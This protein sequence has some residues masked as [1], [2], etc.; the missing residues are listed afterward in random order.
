[1]E[2]D[3]SL[4]KISAVLLAFTSAAQAG[5][6][7]R[8]DPMNPLLVTLWITLCWAILLA[9]L[10]DLRCLRLAK[11]IGSIALSIFAVVGI[12]IAT[13]TSSTNIVLR[14]GHDFDL[15]TTGPTRWVR[16]DAQN[17][18]RKEATCRLM[19]NYFGKDNEKPMLT[20]EIQLQA[21]DGGDGDNRKPI[22]IGVD[23]SH[24]KFDLFMLQQNRDTMQI[25][26]TVE[27]FKALVPQELGRGIYIAHV[28]V[29]GTN[30]ISST[31]NIR[32]EYKGGTDITLQ[33]E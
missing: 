18:S 25:S 14:V 32:I 7:A 6:T 13:F 4:H 29:Q 27:W 24:R 33:T 15:W 12:C 8:G 11:I 23:Y 31:L 10:W 28:Y 21:S 5:F 9:F 22:E 3:K 1:M 2:N 17:K 26:S 20:T 19:L 16:I 30:C